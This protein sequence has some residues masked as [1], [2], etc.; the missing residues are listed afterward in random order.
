MLNCIEKEHSAEVIKKDE[1]K[2]SLNCF[3]AA[4]NTLSLDMF[5]C[6]ADTEGDVLFMNSLSF[7]SFF[8]D[9]V[10]FSKNHYQPCLESEVCVILSE[11]LPHYYFLILVI[12]QHCPDINKEKILENNIYGWQ[13]MNT[14]I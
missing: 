5:P 8:F 10:T 14:F 7:L 2:Q 1:T 13:L 9:F 6:K 11:V 4:K 3:D 12:I